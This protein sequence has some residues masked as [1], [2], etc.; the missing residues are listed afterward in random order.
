MAHQSTR[1]IE[2]KMAVKV[3]MDQKKGVSNLFGSTVDT[4]GNVKA[5]WY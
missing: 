2:K 3:W 5:E 4:V 1:G